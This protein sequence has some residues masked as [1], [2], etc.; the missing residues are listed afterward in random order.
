MDSGGGSPATCLLREPLYCLLHSRDE[1]RAE[2]TVREIREKTNNEQPRYYLAD[3]SSLDEV[4]RLAEEV[5]ADYDR[6]VFL[7]NNARV[8]VRERAISR[9]GHELTFAVNY[10]APFLLT[11]LLVPLLRCSAPT[12]ATTT[13]LRRAKAR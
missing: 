13:S 3:L 2:T 8:F 1:K 4:R 7:I 6:L 9:D 10:L 12:R 11:H 5:R